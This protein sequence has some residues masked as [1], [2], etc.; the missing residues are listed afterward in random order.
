VR[1]CVFIYRQIKR[2]RTMCYWKYA[3]IRDTVESH[4]HA[5]RAYVSSIDDLREMKKKRADMFMFVHEH[6][7]RC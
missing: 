7:R 6:K 3:H 1:V 5:M 2:G 4:A